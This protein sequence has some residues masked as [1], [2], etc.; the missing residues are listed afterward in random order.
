MEIR[1]AEFMLSAAGPAGWPPAGP[2]EVAFAGRS[3]V[4][5][6]SL[7][8]SLVARRGLAD[9]SSTP[10]K[11]RLLNF[12]HVVPVDAPELRF[13]DLPGYGYAK[14]S[15]AERGAFAALVE[16]FVRE[17][18]TLRAVVALVDPRRDA[19]EEEHQL[20]EWLAAVGRPAVVVMT[21][22]DK[23][24]LHERKPAGA[25]LR[26][27]LGLARDPLP[28]SARTGEGRDLLWRRLLALSAPAAAPD[29]AAPGDSGEPAT[30]GEDR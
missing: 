18:A 17:R 10:G 21:K 16:P 26:A 25:R 5:K 1:S 24:A 28:F 9:V 19:G 14:V 11:T 30:G 7:I 3:N 20:L 12:F 22:V 8:N 29:A 2:P 4:G 27:A 15:H 23:L 6:S 13:V